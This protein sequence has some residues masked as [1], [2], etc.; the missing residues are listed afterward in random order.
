MRTQWHPSLEWTGERVIPEMMV[1]DARELQAHTSRYVFALQFCSPQ[2]ARPDVPPTTCVLD[3]ACGVGYG[4]NILSWL[5]KEA[6]GV[7]ISRECVEYANAVYSTPRTHFWVGDA[8]QVAE[9]FGAGYF[10]AVIS[11]ETIEHVKDPLELLM[12]FRKVLKPGGYLVVSAPHGSTS[13]FHVPR[14]GQLH[15]N[16]TQEE[17]T[18]VVGSVFPHWEYHC[19]NERLNFYPH[20]LLDCP[21]RTH[22][23]IAQKES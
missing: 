12:A 6:H 23:V 9:M 21:I 5:A 2:A 19:Q 10:D 11:F 22:F 13:C 1:G 3:A 20:E 18:G 16:Y 4:T 14:E 7:D 8:L 15:G 17:L